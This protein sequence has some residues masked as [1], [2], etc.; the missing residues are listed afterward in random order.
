MISRKGCAVYV[1]CLLLSG[2][3]PKYNNNKPEQKLFAW[4]QQEARLYD[5]PIMI[6][7]KPDYAYSQDSDTAVIAYSVEATFHDI[8]TYYTYQMERQGWRSYASIAAYEKTLIFEK[9]Q[10]LCIISLR[11]TNIARETKIVISQ[12]Y[13]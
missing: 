13:L 3:L 7:A 6:S 11:P 12:A 4:Q 1:I 2:C 5:I 10:K 8:E 9:P